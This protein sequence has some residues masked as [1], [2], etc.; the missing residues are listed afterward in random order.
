[1]VTS[2]LSS[3]AAINTFLSGFLPSENVRF[4]PEGAVNFA[5]PW[6]RREEE[7][8]EKEDE[9]KESSVRHFDYPSMTKT[10]GDFWYMN[11]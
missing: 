11:M 3:R 5:A 6:E 1:M 2:P 8:E 4:R 10:L 9:E 7:E